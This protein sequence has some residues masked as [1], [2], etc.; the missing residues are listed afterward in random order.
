MATTAQ[1]FENSVL[2]L[3][4]LYDTEEAKSIMRLVFQEKLGINR[5]DLAL[6]NHKEVDTKNLKG[7]YQII[8][9]LA[10]G[11]PVQQI[12]GTTNF[13]N[14]RLRVNKSVLIP[15]PETEELVQW[16]LKDN[17]AEEL[18]VLDVGTGSGCIAI[19]LALGLPLSHV[20]GVDISQQALELAQINSI[21]NN[22]YIDLMNLDI[23]QE[24]NWKKLKYFDIIVSNPPYVLESE[25]EEMHINVLDHEP[26]VAL[27]VPDEDPLLF[28]EKIAEMALKHFV[29]GGKLYFEINAAY[30]KQVKKMLT[31]KGYKDVMIK[32]DINDRNRFVKAVFEE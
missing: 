4:E 16:I 2:E 15:R 19:A 26:H 24:D 23:L 6:N 30:G 28:Y 10:K 32:K 5:I 12:L 27:F 31:A 29:K 20:T 14:I 22:A 13:Y 9:K 1:L 11:A 17:T 3:S 18:E 21:S 8:E 25:K 7:I